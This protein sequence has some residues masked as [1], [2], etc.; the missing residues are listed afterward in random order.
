MYRLKL[1]SVWFVK[2]EL[3]LQWN[4]YI[5]L[6][7]KYLHFS[8]H[9]LFAL[10]ATILVFCDSYL[11][12]QDQKFCSV[13]Y[14]KPTIV[15]FAEQQQQNCHVF[16]QSWDY[17]KKTSQLDNFLVNKVMCVKFCP[18]W[19][20][21]LLEIGHVLTADIVGFS[22]EI[23]GRNA[24]I[25]ALVASASPPFSFSAFLPLPFFAPATHF[26]TYGGVPLTV[27]CLYGISFVRNS[28]TEY[29]SCFS[30]V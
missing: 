26:I 18:C 24:K 22:W 5:Q 9:K 30:P 2:K 16:A 21:S 4:L 13:I 3:K 11:M 27:K 15:V 1:S 14:M 20:T 6:C 25:P 10:V 23:G 7:D 29:G 17:F 8:F 28:E 19:E 12:S